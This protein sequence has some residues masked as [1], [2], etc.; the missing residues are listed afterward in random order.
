MQPMLRAV[1][2]TCCSAMPLVYPVAALFLR[3]ASR[4][5]LR[6][7]KPPRGLAC[8]KPRIDPR[9][10]RRIRSRCVRHRPPCLPD[11]DAVIAA[12][13]RALFDLQRFELV[14]ASLREDPYR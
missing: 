2:L 10:V 8:T 3:Q 12:L 9:R 5:E 13:G 7:M 14:L 6:F 1:L 11:P 4:R